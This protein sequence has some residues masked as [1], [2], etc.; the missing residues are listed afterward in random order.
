M[1]DSPRFQHRLEHLGFR[2]AT[3]LVQ[4]F[5]HASVRRF[6]R[7]FGGLYGR[8]DRR[9]RQLVVDNLER[10]FPAWTLEE[11]TSV[12]GACFRAYGAMFFDLV[13]AGRFDE[14]DLESRFAVRG[15]EHLEEAERAGKGL[16]ILTGHFGTWQLAAYYAGWRLGSL[17][18]LARPLNN[19]L[20]EAEARGLRERWGNRQL[21]KRGGAHRMLNVVRRGGRV[22]LLIDQ[23]VRPPDGVLVPFLGRPAWT[24]NAL[25]MLSLH[26]GAPVVPA[27][28]VLE[29][30]EGY[31]LEVERP[32]WPDGKGEAA[33]T[34]FLDR[35]QAPI[36]RWVRESPALWMWMHR[37]W[38][39]TS[40]VRGDAAREKLRDAAQ[41]PADPR[42]ADLEANLAARLDPFRQASWLERGE[43]LTL[44]GA[45][46]PQARHAA[47]ALAHRVIDGG[48]RAEFRTATELAET[49]PS[50]A[51]LDDR[52]RFFRRLDKVALLLV[53][54]SRSDAIAPV[55]EQRRGRRATVLVGE[56]G[57]DLPTDL[58]LRL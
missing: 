24:P 2:F 6:G 51:D 7:R 18:L 12:A 43:S 32:I 48:H 22:A 4:R 29:G 45:D 37:R 20:V 23:R 46:R 17:H 21:A 35:L 28:C 55:L 47:I 50:P 36:E 25:A 56:A 40:P 14:R 53:E 38:Q 31:R 19:P 8:L 1:K 58:V 57:E 41:L 49:L 13:S 42:W 27:Y 30:D 15:W 11:R 39:K 10:A 16:F 9:R 44:L 54:G 26:S 33:E 34:A 52:E 3:G 5:P